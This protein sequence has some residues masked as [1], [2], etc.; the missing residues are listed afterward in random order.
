[1]K[2]RNKR[3]YNIA[4]GGPGSLCR[5]LTRLSFNKTNGCH[6]A[7]G[8]TCPCNLISARHACNVGFSVIVLTACQPGRGKCAP[9]QPM[10]YDFT[11]V[12]MEPQLCTPRISFLFE[13][14]H[15]RQKLHT[16][17]K[18]KFLRVIIYTSYKLKVFLLSHLKISSPLNFTYSDYISNVHLQFF[19][20]NF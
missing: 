19:A 13:N 15:S 18:L 12:T 11:T 7:H 6:A 8:V 9:E 14:F 4:E 5:T 17:T 2:S 20:L 3:I 10:L 16:V 1:M